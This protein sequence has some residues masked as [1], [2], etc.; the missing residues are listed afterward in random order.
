MGSGGWRGGLW[1]GCV[2]SMVEVFVVIQCSVRGV[3]WYRGWH[4]QS[5]EDVCSCGLHK[6]SG[7]CRMCRLVS[8]RFWS[9][10]IMVLLSG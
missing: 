2:V 9:W 1:D 6:S 5:G 8:V 4:V 3:W 7:R 10:W